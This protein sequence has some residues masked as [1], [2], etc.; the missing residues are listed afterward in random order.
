M[1]ITKRLKS[2][3]KKGGIGFLLVLFL[4]G[5]FMTI[6]FYYAI[7]QS[8][9]PIQEIL[10]FPPRFYVS[11]P[12]LDNYRQLFRSVG[13]DWIPFGRYVFNSIFVTLIVT[14]GNVAVSI[15]AAYP[16][17]KLNFKGSKVIFKI[18]TYSLLFSGPVTAFPQYILMAKVGL[19]DTYYA[20][21][22]PFVATPMGA[23]LL[24][25]FLIQLPDT[26]L[27]AARIDGASNYRTLFSVVAP[28]MKPAILTLIILTFQAVWNGGGAS[29]IYTE[30]FKVL[31]TLLS[32]IVA[33]GT[34]RIG[35]GAASAVLM[36]ILPLTVFIITQSQI[37]ETMAF[38]GI[39]E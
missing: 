13:G 32:Q 6:P 23:F 37:I 27:E 15:L 29:F 38:S 28:N 39:K 5:L 33:S 14:V 12:T 19:I 17:A 8:F 30:K 35:V 24:K 7:M 26:M 3:R 2:K 10:I 31:P 1:R 22:L 34:A 25:N 21:I 16:L 18:I 36:M 11:S 4:F 9:K 20:L